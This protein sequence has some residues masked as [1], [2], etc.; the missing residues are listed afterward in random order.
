MDYKQKYL[1]LDFGKVLAGPVSGNWFIT[2]NF[3]KY[4]DIKKFDKD[5]LSETK[6]KYNYIIDAIIK[7]EDEEYKAFVDFYEKILE[8][9]NLEIDIKE[10][11]K[12]LAYDFVYSNEK[13]ELYSDVKENLDRLQK[14]YKLILLSDNWP[15][16]YRIMKLWNIE[17]Y[18]DKIYVSSIYGCQKRNKTFFDYPIKDYDIK[19]NEVVFVDD[20][21]ELLKIAEEKGLI[22]VLM[23]RGNLVNECEYRIISSLDEL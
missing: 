14:E 11:S 4:I 3:S 2:P 16:V 18:F 1:I 9:Q 7:T 5:K 21:I 22:P 15:C 20:N 13:Y 17:K 6:S 12:K 8:E 10:I 23:D 19:A